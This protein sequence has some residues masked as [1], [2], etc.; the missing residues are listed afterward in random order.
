MLPQFKYLYFLVN[1]YK[2]TVLRNCYVIVY[3]GTVGDNL[4]K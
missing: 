1:K 4:M 2:N 3:D